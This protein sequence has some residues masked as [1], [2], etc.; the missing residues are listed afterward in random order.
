MLKQCP[1]SFNHLSHGAPTCGICL[2]APRRGFPMRYSKVFERFNKLM[3]GISPSICNTTFA[4]EFHERAVR[5][6]GIVGE[7]WETV[8]VVRG[9]I[10]HY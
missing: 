2:V 7:K 1:R 10:H 3:G 5:V 4:K 8:V 9:S 6:V